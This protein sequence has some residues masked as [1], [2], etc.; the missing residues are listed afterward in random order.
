MLFTSLSFVLFLICTVV[1][2]YLLPKKAQWPLLLLASLGFYALTDWRYLFFI[3]LTALSVYAVSLR[4]EKINLTQ[5]EYLKQHKGELSKEEKQAYKGKMKAKKWGWLLAALL[6]N[7]G[8]LA[9]TKYTNFVI[10]NINGLL[11]GALALKPVD[12]I[13]P[14][15][16][17]FYT[18]Q[19]LGYLI[20][21]YR[22]KQE[23]QRNPLKFLLFVS[24]FPQLVQGPISRYGD[25]APT[26]FSG[27]RFERK[28]V[29][30]GVMRILWGYFKKVVIADRLLKAVT[31]LVLPGEDGG[32]AYVGVYVFIAMLFYAF[33]LYCDF[34]GGI[35]I[36]I[37]IAETMGIKLAENFRLPYFSKNIKEYWNRWHITMGSWFTDY[38]FY[39]ISV[40]EPM[41]KLSKWSRG[42]LPKFIGKRVTVY[43]ACFVVWLAT[44][45]WHGAAWNFIVWGLANFAVIMISQELEPLY[46]KFHGKFH[47]KDKALYG[48][49]EIVRTILLM[50]A[51]R[52]FD[53]YRDV[54]LTLSM[55]GSMFTKWNF[56]A[57]FD[58]SLLK[59][60]LSASD[61]VILIVGF[62][63]VLTVSILK[64]RNDGGQA[65]VI[66]DAVL[67]VSGLAG[68]V[69][70]H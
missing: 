1:L 43:I 57:L 40:C 52:M 37:G 27:H 11:S 13:I 56:S 38:I 59:I 17:S 26:L 10:D 47:L 24:F 25:L 2:Y 33:Q 4:L 19:S 9:F 34:T 42:H 46:S 3:V 54:P 12:L 62:F 22:G 8:I 14:M 15:G 61:Y 68:N 66:A 41:L 16:I 28:T 67:L 48:V 58:G 53:C 7:L 18:F 63:V 32:Y 20:D 36:T 65:V 64:Q 69:V 31:T 55:L 44:G 60:G 5:K 45:I 39:P 6:L 35:D 49:F 51:I 70:T 30:Y 23:A 21:V 50:S 29:S